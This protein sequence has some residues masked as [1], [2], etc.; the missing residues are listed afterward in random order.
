MTVAE[1]VELTEEEADLLAEIDA[2]RVIYSIGKYRHTL[3]Q[4]DVSL[5]V[6]LLRAR[7]L[8]RRREVAAGQRIPPTR[9]CEL[10][11]HGTEVLDAYRRSRA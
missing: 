6:Q 4:L 7:K 8:V 9:G 1:Q 2:G 3:R 5:P 10:T 11:G